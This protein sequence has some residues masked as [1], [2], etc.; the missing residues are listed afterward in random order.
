M[1]D[2]RLQL[3]L[4][5]FRSLEESLLA[6][7][8]RASRQLLDE[9]ITDDF[10][11]FGVSGRVFDKLDVLEAADRLPDI[12][13]P[14]ADFAVEALSDSVV[15]VTYRSVTRLDGGGS[16]TALRSSIWVRT[17]DRWRLRFHQGTLVGATG[18]RA[19][20]VASD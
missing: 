1:G 10:V 5:S 3:D 18:D 16:S 2:G 7:G 9:L 11:E 12:E 4:D 20:V 17:G 15:L 6:P 8:I 13:T 14:L 19:A